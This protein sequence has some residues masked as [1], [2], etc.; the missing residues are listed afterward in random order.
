MLHF[1]QAN[2]HMKFFPAR[3]VAVD[4]NSALSNSVLVS[5]GT[6]N[7]MRTG[8]TVLDA[9]GY[10]LGTI[11]DIAS[12]TS[13]VLLLTSPS[14]SVGAVDMATGASGLVE[15]QW[16]GRPQFRWVVAS[17]AIRPGDFIITS[18]QMNLYP[19]HLLI[20]Q[21][22][23]VQHSTNELFLSAEIQPLSDLH[24]LEDVQV[25]RNFVPS[26]PTK[27]LSH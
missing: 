9:N 15:G 3:I 27:L 20:G 1:Q 19:R 24:H 13:K 25:V 18:G 8:M 5:A 2:P 14:S 21:V 16:A 10:F 12:N 4:P 7:H 6:K 17:Q 26:I 23:S 11:S 22:V